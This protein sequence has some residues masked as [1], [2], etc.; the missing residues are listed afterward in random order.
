MV[1]TRT[2]LPIAWNRAVYPLLGVA[3]VA[4]HGARAYLAYLQLPLARRARLKPATAGPYAFTYVCRCGGEEVS[5]AHDHR[6][7]GA[8][9]PLPVAR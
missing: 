3:F 2:W 5:H 4:A 7:R 1:C 6:D 9:A 8:P